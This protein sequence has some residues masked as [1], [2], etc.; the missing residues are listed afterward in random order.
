MNL[1]S[2]GIILLHSTVI[3]AFIPSQRLHHRQKLPPHPVEATSQVK[4]LLPWNA[5]CVSQLSHPLPANPLTN[6]SPKGDGSA[7]KTLPSSQFYAQ[8][9]TSNTVQL[10]SA[11]R[12]CRRP[13]TST[14][15]APCKTSSLLQSSVLAHTRASYLS[16][17]TSSVPCRSSCSHSRSSSDGLPPTQ[18][19]I[20]IVVT[21]VTNVPKFVT[22]T[23]STAVVIVTVNP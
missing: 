13:T 2:F 17:T 5:T 9:R 10:R 15:Y 22:T 8:N 18:P 6:T 12:P 23:T 21:E 20:T 4:R 19:V 3:L 16:N 1:C 14:A 11:T 7:E